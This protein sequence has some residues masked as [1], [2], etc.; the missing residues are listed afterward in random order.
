M[1]RPPNLNRIGYLE[2]KVRE[3]E[4]DAARGRRLDAVGDTLGEP[5]AQTL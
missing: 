3:E 2:A 1:I 5:H 4:S